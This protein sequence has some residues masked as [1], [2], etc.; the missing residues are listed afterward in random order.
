MQNKDRMV[1]LVSILVLIYVLDVRTVL[2]HTMLFI[3]HVAAQYKNVNI[4]LLKVWNTM[5]S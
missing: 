2:Q 4:I 1:G 5:F 3:H